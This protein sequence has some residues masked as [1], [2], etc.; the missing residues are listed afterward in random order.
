MSQ[1][2]RVQNK[3]G[4][5]PNFICK[6]FQSL[7]ESARNNIRPYFALSRSAS[8][9]WILLTLTGVKPDYDISSFSSCFLRLLLF[10]EVAL[11]F[12]GSC[13][14]SALVTESNEYKVFVLSNH[15]GYRCIIFRTVSSST[16]ILEVQFLDCSLHNVKVSK[17]NTGV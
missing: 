8:R 3:R 16:I 6:Y 11:P 14:A 17:E 12:R 7:D 5:G 2:E 10:L 4:T 9:R 15:F 1:P 13:L